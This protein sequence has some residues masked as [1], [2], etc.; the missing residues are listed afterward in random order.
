MIT[1]RFDDGP[2]RKMLAEAGRQM[3]YA[4]M[5][6]LNDLAFMIRDKEIETMKNVFK[7]PKPQ[8]LKN[9]RARLATKSNLTTTIAFNQ[10]WE[11][12]E[13]MKVEIDGGPRPL[14]RSEKRTF[15][16]RF[17]VPGIGARL[18]ENGDISG[19]QILQIMS[20][21]Q[22]YSERGAKMNRTD[23][24]RTAAGK[25]KTQYFMLTQKTNGLAA[26]VYMRVDKGQ[27]QMLYARALA[28]KP[29]DEEGKRIKKADIRAQYRGRLDRGVVPVLI[30]VAKAP[31]YQA[32]FPFY[33][34]GR[35]VMA[36]NATRIIQDRVRQ[37]LREAR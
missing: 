26:G 25:G 32:R 18:D 30:F 17:Y 36:D 8:T 27:G 4:T 22:L 12:D 1:L 23:S 24:Q 14:K 10:L 6:A 11:W 5:L 35:Q 28:S 37:V 7:H 16:G 3:P 19:G 34:V 2:F 31:T 13:Y 20:Y 29:R 9:I 21:L 33:A 15:G